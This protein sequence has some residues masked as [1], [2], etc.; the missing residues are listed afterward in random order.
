M[1]SLL[2][3]GL[4]HCETG[5]TIALLLDSP[6]PDSTIRPSI[7]TIAANEHHNTRSR[8]LSQHFRSIRRMVSH[9]SDGANSCENQSQME[10]A[11]VTTVGGVGRREP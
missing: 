9:S 4:P 8:C 2:W 3:F 10:F 6:S 5:H 11:A 7:I 1:T